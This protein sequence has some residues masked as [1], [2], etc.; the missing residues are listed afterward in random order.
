MCA[1]AMIAIIFVLMIIQVIMTIIFMGLLMIAQC[2]KTIF[3]PRE[4]PLLLFIC[5]HSFR[6]CSYICVCLSR[7]LCLPLSVSVCLCL[8]LALSHAVRDW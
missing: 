5:F 3:I 4:C 6:V 1:K 8:F 2:V 7:C